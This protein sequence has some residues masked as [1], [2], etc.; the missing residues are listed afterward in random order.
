MTVPTLMS[1]IDKQTYV[2][3]AK[4][5][6]SQLQ[7]TTKMLPIS[8]GCSN[9]DFSCL[10][11]FNEGDFVKSE[12]ELM[13]ALAAQMKT[14][15]Q[16]KN[17][18]GCGPYEMSRY[19]S[20]P[21]ESDVLFSTAFVTSDNMAYAMIYQPRLTDYLENTDPLI[22]VDVNNTKGPNRL[23][24]DIFAFGIAKHSK[25]DVPA[26]TVLPL[27]SKIYAKYV[28]QGGHATP[29]TWDKDRF[30]GCANGRLRESAK[31]SGIFCTGRVLE[32]GAMNY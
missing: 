8:L 24:R 10:P 12:G 9:G 21:V 3:G 29:K 18:S 6:Y 7:N 14:V 27:G 19:L 22:L 31:D 2:T 5:A 16:C 1:N 32:E 20:G 17:S 23:G 4:K 28:S 25:N 15:K 30:Y 26:G 13:E 11:S